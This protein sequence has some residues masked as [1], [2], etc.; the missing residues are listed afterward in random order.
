MKKEKTTNTENKKSP[1]FRYPLRRENHVIILFGVFLLIVGY[2]LMGL[3]K[4]PDAFLTRTLAPLILVISYA[5]IIPIGILYR[6]K[7]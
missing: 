7:S 5:I 2:V 6:K 1:W 4:D 3:P